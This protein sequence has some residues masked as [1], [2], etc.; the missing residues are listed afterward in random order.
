MKYQL[1]IYILFSCCFIQESLAQNLVKNGGFEIGK[2][3][4]RRKFTDTVC[5]YWNSVGNV[6]YFSTCSNG[7]VHPENNFVGKQNT[8]SGKA[9]VGLFTGTGI[10]SRNTELLYTELT[11]PL[12]KGKHY[13]LS[14]YF[15]LAEMSSLTSRAIG[16]TFSK[17]LAYAEEVDESSAVMYIPLID[18][19]Y[20][21]LESDQRVLSRDDKWS[22]FEKEYIAQGGDKYLYIGGVTLKGISCVKRENVPPSIVLGDYAYY[23]IDEV[24]LIKQ[25][26][27]GSYPIVT[28][29]LKFDEKEGDNYTFSNVYFKA[30]SYQ[31]LDTSKSS[32]DTLVNIM[33]ENTS[34]GLTLQGH[35]DTVGDESKNLILSERRA[36]EVKKYLMTQGVKEEK[37]EIKALGSSL[38]LNSN[39]TNTEREKNRR[40]E[41]SLVKD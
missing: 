21:L 27:N 28:S 26:D 41:I 16:S 31:L 14:F 3:P 13:K 12:I 5:S 11:E 1:Y 23:Y 40:V 4:N 38:P 7:E 8:Y 37:I 20:L 6:D 39:D 33:K 30:S 25:N 36:N 35:T 22:L 2:C 18:L 15:S 10:T 19:K 32:L 29:Q 17:E 24:A 34:W 9:Y